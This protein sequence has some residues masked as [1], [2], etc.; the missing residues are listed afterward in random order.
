MK[1]TIKACLD[2]IGNHD[3]D[4]SLFKDRKWLTQKLNGLNYALERLS[5]AEEDASIFKTNVKTFLE[6]TQSK[7]SNAEI[8]ASIKELI[9]NIDVMTGYKPL[10]MP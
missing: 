2:G 4:L 10:E 1:V 7:S 8:R 9:K 3:A 5:I 6:K